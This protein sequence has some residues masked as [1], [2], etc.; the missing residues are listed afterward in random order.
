MNADRPTVREQVI[1]GAD[2]ESAH[3]EE[4]R[5]LATEEE[6]VQPAGEEQGNLSQAD[7]DRIAEL[8]KE[9]KLEVRRAH[10]QLG[11]PSP[12]V[13]ARLCKLAKKSADHIW[14]AKKFQCPVC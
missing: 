9:L 4:L 13:L 12:A 14:Y 11:H 6:F 5:R 10:H 2:A 1:D 7:M 8:P 3:L